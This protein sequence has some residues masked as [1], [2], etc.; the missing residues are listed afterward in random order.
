[1]VTD[2][3]LAMLKHAQV[4]DGGLRRHWAQVGGSDGKVGAQFGVT[5]F[6]T[7]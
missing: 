7:G 3:Y 1:M 4:G 2:W 6:R 5:P